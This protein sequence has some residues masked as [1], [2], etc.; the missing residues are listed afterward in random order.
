MPRLTT[1]F[2]FCRSVATWQQ[3]EEPKRELFPEVLH[4]KQMIAN[5]SIGKEVIAVI[6]A[7]AAVVAVFMPKE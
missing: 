7:A 6:A 5:F 3:Y 4:L 2:S 1:G